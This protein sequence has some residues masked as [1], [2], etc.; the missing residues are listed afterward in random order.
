MLGVILEHVLFLVAIND[1]NS[2]LNDSILLFTDDTT[3]SGGTTPSEV[4]SV[5]ILD[6]HLDTKLSW[7]LH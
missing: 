4:T 6:F 5:K 3:K 7:G 1:L 2:S